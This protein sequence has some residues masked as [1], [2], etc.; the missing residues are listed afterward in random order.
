MLNLF[1]KI[2]GLG[3]LLN[4]QKTVIGAVLKGVSLVG[5]YFPAFPA[6]P[7]MNALGEI[8]DVLFYGGLVHWRI[9]DM[10]K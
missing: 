1:N 6:Q 4:G 10:M 2:L 9:K 7:V 5:G 8:G 3:G